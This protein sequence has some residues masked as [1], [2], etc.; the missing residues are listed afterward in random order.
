MARFVPNSWRTLFSAAPDGPP[1]AAPGGRATDA[2]LAAGVFCLLLAAYLLTHGGDF[3]VSDGVVMLRTTEAIVERHAVEVAADPGLSQIVPG[4]DGKFFSKYGLGQ[5]LAATIPF[6]LAQW[7]HPIFFEYMWHRGLEGYF[8]SLF[9]QFVT[10]AT[11]VVVYLLARRLSAGPRMAVLLA[12]AW[13]LCTLAWPYAKT[14]FSEPLF[15]LC[16]VVC[17]YALLAYR[18]APSGRRFGWLALG[19]AGLGYALIT[20]ISGATLV[21]LFAVYAGWAALAHPEGDLLR[22]LAGRRRRS[23]PRPA[24]VPPALALLA[25]GLPLLLALAVILRHNW[26]RF[27]DVWNNGYAGAGYA[28]E[29]FTTFLPIG[30]AGLLLSSGKSIFVYVPLTALS[31]LAWPRFLR[32]LPAT[33]LLYAGIFLV[34]LVQSS[35]WWAWW[36]GWSWGPRLLVPALPFFILALIPALHQSARMRLAGWLLAGVSFLVTLLGVLVDFNPHLSAL[37]ALYPGDRPGT[38]DPDVYFVVDHAPILAHL[39]YLLAGDHISVVTFDLERLGFSPA[40]AAGFP[41]IVAA[42][43]VLAVAL[44]ACGEWRMRA[45]RPAGAG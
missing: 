14:F 34:M 9:N 39:R 19:A 6:M 37:M 15:T 31:V 30:V 23:A 11:G 5:P 1:P 44:L 17:A 18:Q 45:G 35:V 33:A 4:R 12:L 13:G 10:A 27:D 42:L 29:G 22:R 38:E 8:V 41:Y 16:I 32:A 26:L 24:L 36:G 21:P 28:D 2:L 7:L 20:R 25:F 43:F 40:H 3:F